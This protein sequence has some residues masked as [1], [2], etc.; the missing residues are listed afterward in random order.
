[1]RY[2]ERKVG[3]YKMRVKA[4][5]GGIHKSLR[6]KPD[7]ERE[8]E[9]LYAL[10]QEV[11]AGMTVMD[12]GANVGYVSLLLAD[13]VGPTG[14]VYAIEPDPANFDLLEQNIKLNRYSKR[15]QTYQMGVSSYTENI[16]FYVGKSSNLGGMVQT[17]NTRTE[18]IIVEVMSLERFLKDKEYPQLIKMDIEGHEVEV[19]EGLR[20]LLDDPDFKCK[21]IMELHP[22]MYSEDHSLER[23]MRKLLNKG[24]RTKY[25][26]SAG[27]VQPD[28]FKEWGY[29]PIMEFAS[30]RGLYDNFTDEHM[31]EACCHLNKQ[32]MPGKRK[33][34]PKIAR[35]VM[36]ERD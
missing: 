8:P 15:F 14:K 13:L 35:F 16:N 2:V 24:F 21:I 11:K 4:N 19:L 20:G 7:K 29:E 25:V 9:L 22:N 1:M 28:K 3:K 18:P 23:Q 30:L 26:I 12:L 5:E 34:S 17:K 31:I 27:V 6:E 36:I 33:Y 10:R 32:W